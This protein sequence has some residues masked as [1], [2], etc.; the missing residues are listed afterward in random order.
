[1]QPGMPRG[2]S[3]YGL[4]DAAW[5]ELPIFKSER[6]RPAGLVFSCVLH[7]PTNV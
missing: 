6:P 2:L 7:Y 3:D 5:Q 4:I 1:V